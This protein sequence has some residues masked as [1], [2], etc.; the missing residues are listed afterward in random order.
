MVISRFED[1]SM[2]VRMMYLF[3]LQGLGFDWASPTGGR[4]IGALACC[5]L[6]RAYKYSCGHG[7]MRL[8][9]GAAFCRRKHVMVQLHN[10]KEK[11]LMRCQTLKSPFSY[12]CLRENNDLAHLLGCA[13]KMM[14]VSRFDF[15]FNNHVKRS[16]LLYTSWIFCSW[17]LDNHGFCVG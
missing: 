3:H 15:S 12:E 9:K 6:W 8:I 1:C 13:P 10:H 11:F 2:T 7:E 14:K 16:M 5:R 17:F 4:H